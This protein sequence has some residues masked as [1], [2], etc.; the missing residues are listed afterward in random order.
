MPSEVTQ[1]IGAR[2]AELANQQPAVV[3][4]RSIES[5]QLASNLASQ[6]RASAAQSATTVTPDQRRAVQRENKRSEGGFAAQERPKESASEESGS[7]ESEGP[8][9]KDSSTLNKVA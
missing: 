8:A 3:Q 1:S 7:S 9:K 5:N 6:N 2:S 4:N